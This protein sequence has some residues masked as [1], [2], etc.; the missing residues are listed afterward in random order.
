[1]LI[2]SVVRFFCALAVVSKSQYQQVIDELTRNTTPPLDELGKLLLAHL[3]PSHF[4]YFTF[5]ITFFYQYLL[6]H[7]FTPYSLR[8]PILCY[9]VH[10]VSITITI[11]T[12][13]LATS[14]PSLFLFLLSFLFF[15]PC[16]FLSL[17]P[18][19]F[20]HL[21]ARNW[22][23]FIGARERM[24]SASPDMLTGIWSAFGERFRYHLL[25][26][27]ILRWRWCTHIKRPGR[28]NEMRI[29]QIE[30]ELSLQWMCIFVA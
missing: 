26:P 7:P 16:S 2:S 14:L 17:P 8:F 21:L 25:K 3:I 12:I 19:F 6:A 29:A 22:Q 20:P 11:T 27:L 28:T 1:M 30:R 9:L 15:Y 10:Q 24:R 18:S 5:C 4:S 23:D 13:S